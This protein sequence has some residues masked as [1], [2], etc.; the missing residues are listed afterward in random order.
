VVIIPRPMALWDLLN[1]TCAMIPVAG[2][3]FEARAAKVAVG[4]WIVAVIVGLVL[5]LSCAWVLWSVGENV[6]ARVRPYPKPRQ[7]WYLR[8]LYVTA[9]LWLLCV[10]FLTQLTLSAVIRLL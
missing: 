5:G 4:G 9:V 8:T 10:A 2:A 1:L 6:V 3:V 7:D